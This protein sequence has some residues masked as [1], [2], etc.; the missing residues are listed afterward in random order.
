MHT[1]ETQEAL[2]LLTEQ[3]CV[4]TWVWWIND[5]CSLLQLKKKQY[6]LHCIQLFLP[7]HH[8]QQQQLK[9]WQFCAWFCSHPLSACLPAIFLQGQYLGNAK[10]LYALYQSGKLEQRLLQGGISSFGAGTGTG[11]ETSTSSLIEHCCMHDT[12]CF[13]T[14]HLKPAIVNAHVARIASL[15]V[16]LGGTISY[17][18]YNHSSVCY[19]V[20]SMFV[21]SYSFYNHS[22]VRYMVISI[23]V[24]IRSITLWCYFHLNHQ[25]VTTP[26]LCW[27]T[28]TTWHFLQCCILLDCSCL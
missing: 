11:T 18:L 8:P 25:Q 17:S 20:I 19:M 13:E 16:L 4:N 23:F 10:D 28:V 12:N 2:D 22:S 27:C 15:F 7:A 6:I 24:K 3:L 14:T 26:I 5:V 21:I 1:V 9:Q